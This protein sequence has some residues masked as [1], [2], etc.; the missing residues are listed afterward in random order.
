VNNVLK[1]EIEGIHGLQVRV[2][3][4]FIQNMYLMV[5][6]LKTIPHWIDTILDP[7]IYFID[8]IFMIQPSEH[9]SIIYSMR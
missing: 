9:Q 5:A 2:D 6:Q 1:K 4:S 3:S 8:A 7:T